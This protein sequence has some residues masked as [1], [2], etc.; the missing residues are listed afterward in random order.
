M[1]RVLYLTRTKL[2]LSRAHTINILKTAQ[3][4]AQEPS[5]RVLVVSLAGE[6][7]AVDQI[8]RDK[9]INSPV[10]LNVLPKKRSALWYLVRTTNYD[11]LYFRDPWL[12]FPALFARLVG[13]KKIVFEV[14][15]SY[16]WRF[17]LPLWHFAVRASD[18]AVFI[19]KK[20]A[21]YYHSKKPYVVAPT[22]AVTLEAYST[23]IDLAPVGVPDGSVVIMYV[24][25]FLWYSIDVLVGMMQELRGEKV[26]LVFVGSTADDEKMISEKMKKAELEGRYTVIRR[27]VPVEVSKYLCAADILVNP[28]ATDYPGSISSKLYEYLAAGKPIITTLGG[29]NDEIII[30]NENGIIVRELN[31]KLF[32]Q[33][34]LK[35]LRDKKFAT[36]IGEAA[37]FSTRQYTWEAR[38]KSIHGLL[39]KVMRA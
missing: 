16:E 23:P 1:I 31:G 6:S 15:G 27:V 13:G 20:L 14:H 4:L 2:A 5:V 9:G 25:S 39:E 32:A 7:R 29:A 17:L 18:G 21:Q 8:L 19:T 26:H 30:D 11:V 10:S 22:N 34:A 12:V 35:V 38:A 28:L 24:G 3:Y 37:R 33:A 36:R